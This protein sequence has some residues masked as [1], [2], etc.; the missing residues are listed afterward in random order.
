MSVLSEGERDGERNAFAFSSRV[1]DASLKSPRGSYVRRCACA[2]S[3][4]YRDRNGVCDWECADR[5]RAGLSE[6]SLRGASDVFENLDVREGESKDGRSR[7]TRGDDDLSE[8]LSPCGFGLYSDLLVKGLSRLSDLFGLSVR[9]TR[10][11]RSR[12]AG[13]SARSVEPRDD[14]VNRLSR[15]FDSFLMLSPLQAIAHQ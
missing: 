10:S 6:Y 11:Y 3:R 14:R 5:G 8:Y 9:S 7:C 1:L 13:R 4:V 2:S 15:G 12:P